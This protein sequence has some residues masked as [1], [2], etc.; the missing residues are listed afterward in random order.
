MIHQW[1]HEGFPIFP[2]VFPAFFCCCCY[3]L[4]H[5]L[6]LATR[7]DCSIL[8]GSSSVHRHLTIGAATRFSFP[9]YSFCSETQQQVPRHSVP[10]PETVSDAEVISGTSFQFLIQ[11]QKIFWYFPFFFPPLLWSMNRRDTCWK[12]WRDPYLVT[13]KPVFSF[14]ALLM[15][16]LYSDVLSSQRKRPVWVRSRNIFW[17]A[18]EW[19]KQ[20]SH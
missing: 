6:P 4:L 12:L 3:Q 5:I 13:R 18:L 14:F 11:I 20:E 9:V 16:V 10:A 19:E 17:F 8:L 7:E 15:Q 2:P 1:L